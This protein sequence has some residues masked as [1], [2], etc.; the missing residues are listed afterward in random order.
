MA[1]WKPFRGSRTALDAIEKH[2][3]YVYFCTDD[4]SLFF[5]YADVDGSLQRKQIS[6]NDAETLCGMTLEELKA[7]IASQDIVVLSESQAY[8]DRA[9]EAVKYDSSTQDAVILAEAQ[10]YADLAIEDAKHDAATM[11]AVVLAES[12][13]YTDAQIAAITVSVARASQPILTTITIPAA[14]WS[15]DA[16]P[17]SQ[18][19]TV[20]GA[21]ANSKLDLQ[22]TALQVVALQ[23]AGITLMV[24]ND[25]GVITAWAIGNK[26]TE[27]YT[28]K[29]LITEVSIGYSLNA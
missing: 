27:D 28:M 6:A 14:N 12:Q 25:D 15:G 4:G 26:P 11:D 3:G 21:T 9:I 22:P 13:A 5:D 20:D 16:N 24:Q 1:L 10:N 2:D 7:Y 29:A 8:T 23:D 19:I 18:V 17:W